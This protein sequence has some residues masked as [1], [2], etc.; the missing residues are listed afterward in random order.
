MSLSALARLTE[1]SYA[2]ELP[3]RDTDGIFSFYVLMSGHAKLIY[4]KHDF[5]PVRICGPGDILGYGEWNS[6]Y[7]HRAESLDDVR[8]WCIPRIPF[9]KLLHTSPN[10]QECIIKVLCDVISIKDERISALENHSVSNRVASVLLSFSQKFG[11]ETE[12]GLYID[13]KIDRETMAKLAGTVTESLSRQLSELEE[14]KIILRKG[15]SILI[16]NRHKLEL[17]TRI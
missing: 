8:A 4:Q 15:R 5:F 12:E 13:L 16:K 2:E 3:F 6:K 11:K 9:Q 7:S 10:L 17:K 14:E 1:F